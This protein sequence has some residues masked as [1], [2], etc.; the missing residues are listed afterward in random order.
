MPWFSEKKRTSSHYPL[1]KK[2]LD[3]NLQ[4]YSNE[5]LFF[6]QEYNNTPGTSSPV[7]AQ[8]KHYSEPLYA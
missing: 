6:C 8:T 4:T 3:H 1:P 7:L 5:P 2:K